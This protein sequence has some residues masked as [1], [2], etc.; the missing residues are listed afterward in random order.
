MAL[1]YLKNTKVV[2]NNIL[3]MMGDFNICDKFWD[4]NYLFHST[5]SNLLIDIVDS[6]HLGLLFLLNHVLTR[7]SDNNHKSNLIINLMFLRYGSE[8]LDNYF[9]HPE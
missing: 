9:I 4:P 1:K 3:I 6:M 8:E 5:Y 2:I 7:Y